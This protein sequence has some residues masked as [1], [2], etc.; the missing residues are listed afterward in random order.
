MSTSLTLF[1]PFLCCVFCFSVLCSV[2]VT[3]TSPATTTTPADVD[4]DI[5]RA[6]DLHPDTPIMLAEV[7]SDLAAFV[8]ERPIAGTTEDM[9]DTETNAAAE[10]EETTQTEH[11]VRGKKER[12]VLLSRVSVLTCI[13][14][15]ATIATQ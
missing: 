7:D 9:E 6:S 1:F 13:A 3:S 11:D 5:L 10:E 14:C 4:D 8:V 12:T 2:V 15:I